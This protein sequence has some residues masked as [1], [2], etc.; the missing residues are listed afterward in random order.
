MFSIQT[1]STG[2]SN[3]IHFLSSVVDEEKSRNVFAKTPASQINEASESQSKKKD[4]IPC[5]NVGIYYIIHKS[6][7]I[8]NGDSNDL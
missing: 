5:L 4:I 2:P 7:G 8:K 3:I 1:A 6:R